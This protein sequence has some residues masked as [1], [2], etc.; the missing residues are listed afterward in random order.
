MGMN[1]LVVR[2][3]PQGCYIDVLDNMWNVKGKSTLSRDSVMKSLVIKHVVIYEDIRHERNV[4]LLNQGIEMLMDIRNDF[5][6][7]IQFKICLSWYES[8][9]KELYDVL[10]YMQQGHILFDWVCNDEGLPIGN[11]ED[12]YNRHIKFNQDKIDIFRKSFNEKEVC[13][14]EGELYEFERKKN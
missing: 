4:Y 7:C 14:T 8:G 3:L 9:L 11:F 6:T 5:V 10:Q 13:L 2:V 1:S 12:F